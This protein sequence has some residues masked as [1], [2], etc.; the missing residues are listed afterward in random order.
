MPTLLRQMK[1]VSVII[2]VLSIILCLCNFVLIHDYS[3][4]F[5]LVWIGNAIVPPLLSIFISITL[6]KLCLEL[7][8]DK[9][10]TISMITDLKKELE[11]AKTD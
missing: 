5:P 7:E 2:S 3:P 4:D 1:Q 9:L 6:K 10:S 8:R 11:K